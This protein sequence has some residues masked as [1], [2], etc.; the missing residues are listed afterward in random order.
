MRAAAAAYEKRAQEAAAAGYKGGG[1]SMTEF[2][3]DVTKKKPAKKSSK[4][5]EGKILV[6]S[7][8]G[9]KGYIPQEQLDD[10]IKAGYKKSD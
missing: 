1:P 3:E 7:P 2:M 8:D 4:V 6:I 5:P 9:K 10:A